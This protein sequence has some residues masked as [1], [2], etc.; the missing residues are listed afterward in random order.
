MRPIH[1]IIINELF[2]LRRP[3]SRKW[4]LSP[5]EK[6]KLSPWESVRKKTWKPLCPI[7]AIIINELFVFIEASLEEME[8]QCMGMSEE[9]KMEALETYTCYHY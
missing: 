7:H 4:K 9:E 8:A 3:P 6:W 2:V 1:A 5:W